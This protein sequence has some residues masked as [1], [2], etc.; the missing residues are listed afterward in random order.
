MIDSIIERFVDVK[1]EMKFRNDIT[2]YGNGYYYYSC[3]FLGE[4]CFPREE[5][6]LE[7]IGKIISRSLVRYLSSVMTL[8][9]VRFHVD[10]WPQNFRQSALYT[11][12]CCRS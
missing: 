8:K 3:G 11:R 6:L 1:L 7:R 9:N 5:L 2:V 10:Y 12:R 4:L